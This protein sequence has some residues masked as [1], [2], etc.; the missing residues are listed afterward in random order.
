V[1]S[2]HS[3][4]LPVTHRAETSMSKSEET[5]HHTSPRR[6]QHTSG[7][8]QM[9]AGNR[10]HQEGTQRQLRTQLALCRFIQLD[11]DWG[12][13]PGPRLCCPVPGCQPAVWPFP[14][15]ANGYTDGSGYASCSPLSCWPSQ[16]S[17]NLTQ[18]I[19]P[20]LRLVVMTLL[21]PFGCFPG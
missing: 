4:T 18:T 12:S 21:S 9:A 15:P 11:L 14:P 13:C 16:R 20:L 3:Q 7:P 10:V 1:L 2:W 19:F 17:P 8:P 5:P 6:A